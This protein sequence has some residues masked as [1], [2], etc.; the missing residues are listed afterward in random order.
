MSNDRKDTKISTSRE[1]SDDE[2]NTVSGGTY[3]I[4]AAWARLNFMCDVMAGVAAYVYNNI[5]D[6]ARRD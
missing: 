3:D 5:K 2:L 1:L 4:G 6:A